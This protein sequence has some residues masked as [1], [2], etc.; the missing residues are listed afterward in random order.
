M[1][2]AANESEIELDTL[3]SQ[4]VSND[5]DDK[6]QQQSE[7]QQQSQNGSVI[8][9]MYNKCRDTWNH[10]R[11]NQTIVYIKDNNPFV[12]DQYVCR[13]R[14]CC[15]VTFISLIIFLAI[16]LPL[17]FCVV[18]PSVANVKYTRYIYISN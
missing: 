14:F 4:L 10:R 13:W 7:Q 8:S 15:A 1:V 16:F 18:V 12:S 6:Q 11:I 17:V 9:T 5:G 3:E 2:T